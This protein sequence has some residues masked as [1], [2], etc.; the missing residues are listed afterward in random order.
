[1]NGPTDLAGATAKAAFLLVA[2][3]WIDR[4]LGLASLL[5]VARLL[6]PQDFGTSALAMSFVGICA[7]LTELNTTALLI[8]TPSVTPALLR[9]AWTISVLRGIAVAALLLLI[10]PLAASISGEPKIEPV[11]HVLAIVPLA[12]GLQNVKVALLER[13]LTYIPILAISIFTK[14][15]TTI[16]AVLYALEYG[17]YWAIVYANVAGSLISMAAGYVVRPWAP[18]LGLSEWRRV[19]HFS[20][21]LTGSSIAMAL[22]SRMDAIILSRSDGISA[23]GTYQM[24]RELSVLPNAEIAQPVRRALLPAISKLAGD[25]QRWKSSVLESLSIVTSVVFPISIGAALVIPAILPA[26]LGEQWLLAVGP[27]QILLIEGALQVLGGATGLAFVSKG[28]TRT[29][30]NNSMVFAMLRLPIFV[31]GATLADL[32]GAVAACLTARL[33]Y[34]GVLLRSLERSAKIDRSDVALSVFRPIF[35][36]FAMVL[37]TRLVTGEIHVATGALSVAMT[38]LVGAA[39]YTSCHYVLW[40]SQSRPRGIERRA[41]DL[42]QRW[43]SGRQA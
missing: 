37:V 18:R 36:A 31:A 9:T 15:S 35:S 27:L 29:V 30:F 25:E 13:D 11:L 43:T 22:A 28:D 10:A 26:V 23:V 3:K 33:L 16:V 7:T 38:V 41:L 40:T 12:S 1:M 39:T 19:F 34:T 4:V 32:Q 2:G 21:W 17:D 14:I 6:A 5:I 42:M 24:S 8:Q 20:G